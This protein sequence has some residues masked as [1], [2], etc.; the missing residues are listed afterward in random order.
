M[1]AAKHDRL[2]RQTTAQEKESRALWPVKFVRSET[3]GIDQ[4]EVDVD[5]A[6]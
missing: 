6:R 1:R 5:F 4:R 2:D 3:C